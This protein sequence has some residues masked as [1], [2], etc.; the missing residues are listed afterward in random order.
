MDKE[1]NDNFINIDK[2]D[3]KYKN[4]KEVL[5]E[6]FKVSHDI[7]MLCKLLDE[8]DNKSDAIEKFHQTKS[9]H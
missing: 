5:D 4:E 3:E 7:S 9:R 1:E 6:Y 2:K 8:C